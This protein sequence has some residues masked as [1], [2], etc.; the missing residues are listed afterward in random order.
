MLD[1]YKKRYP[2]GSGLNINYYLSKPLPKY[3]Y[4]N[5]IDSD[6]KLY[7]AWKEQRKINTIEDLPERH[8]EKIKQIAF[9]IIIKFPYIKEL[10]LTGSF[11]SGEW[12]DE[13]STDSE[14]LLKSKVMFKDKNSDYDFI[15]NPIILAHTKEYHLINSVQSTKI[16]LNMSSW[17]LAALPIEYHAKVVK[18][19]KDND[20]TIIKKLFLE[21]KV[22]DCN[23]CLINSSIKEWMT[24]AI[25][26]KTY[27][28]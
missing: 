26:T 24:Y 12:L 6:T 23:S 15:S 13:Y 2:R 5:T 8:I 3:K 18:A 4:I 11:V 14:R 27:E 20:Y 10:Y 21:Y 17:N 22:V 9:N 7:N 25:E 16:K 1:I 19:F 28:E